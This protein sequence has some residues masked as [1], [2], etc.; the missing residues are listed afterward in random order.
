MT[1]AK[2]GPALASDSIDFI[3]KN[4]TGRIFLRLFE[5]VPDPGGAHTHEHLYKIRSR[6]REKRHL[7]FPG[8]CPGQ[9]GLAGAW[10]ACHQH[11]AW[12]SASELLE[13][14]RILKEFDQFA[15]LFLGFINACDILE[16]H[17]VFVFRQHPCFALAETQRTTPATALHLAHEKYPHTDEQQQREPADEYLHQQ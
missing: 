16:G 6:D 1:A 9:Q 4:D 8:N 3:D 17:I 11:T 7:G 2:S 13:T 10:A 14:G 5:H 15:H 12:D